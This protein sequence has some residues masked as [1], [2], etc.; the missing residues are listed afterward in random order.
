M[1]LPFCF[2]AIQPAAHWDPGPEGHDIYGEVGQA[3]ARV[4]VPLDPQTVLD[5]LRIEQPIR[6]A[7]VQILKRCK[8]QLASYL[9]RPPLE[10][11]LLSPSSELPLLVSSYNEA[12]TELESNSGDHTGLLASAMH[13]LG[14]LYLHQHNM[15]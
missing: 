8:R 7:P 6:D 1:T 13:D 14:K 4:C 5:N 2:P 10:D 9:A 12:I 3:L 15:K 11:G